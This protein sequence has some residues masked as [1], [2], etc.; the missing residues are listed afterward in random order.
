MAPPSFL[1]LVLVHAILLSNTASATHTASTANTISIIFSK[2]AAANSTDDYQLPVS[3]GA[4]SQLVYLTPSTSTD[5][6]F[7]NS[8]KTCTPSSGN[9]TITASCISY[10]GGVFGPPQSSSWKPGTAEFSWR[11]D[12]YGVF[13]D[14]DHGQ[15]TVVLA[16][17]DLTVKK[18]DFAVVDACNLTAGF[19]GLGRNSTILARLVADKVIGSQSYGLHVGIDL[20]N[21]SY[22]IVDPT[23]GRGSGAVKGVGGG[24]NV[25]AVHSFPGSLTLGGYDRG[26]IDSRGT[27][28]APISSDGSLEL[29]V[30]N[31][32]LLNEWATGGGGVAHDVLNITRT[33]VIDSSTPY[34]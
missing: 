17:G 26:K 12:E 22:P 34:M 23:F 18:F 11:N 1:S 9:T 10:H 33:V 6:T 29:E 5:D 14:G 15:D 19:L 30:T 16:G 28:E 25:T 7:V 31:V 4:G 32:V 8:P 21:F 27:L 13:A 2:T 20:S 3:V 24:A